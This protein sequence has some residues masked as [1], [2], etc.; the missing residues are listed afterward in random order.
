MVD[1]QGSRHCGVWEGQMVRYIWLTPMCREFVSMQPY[2]MCRE[3][4][5]M[6]QTQ[7][8][9]DHNGATLSLHQRPF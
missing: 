5:S 1:A 6:Y 2:P 9:L 3:F 4:V 8:L 7:E